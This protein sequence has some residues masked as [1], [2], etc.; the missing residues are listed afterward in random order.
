MPN[1][2]PPPPNEQPNLSPEEAVALGAAIQ[3]ACLDGRI[4]QRVF[5]PYFHDRSPEGM[6]MTSG[7]TRTRPERGQEREEEDKGVSL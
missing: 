6:L 4:E 2:P 1:S 5:N 7:G 3:A